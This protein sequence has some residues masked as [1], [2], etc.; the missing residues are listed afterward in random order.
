MRKKRTTSGLILAGTSLASIAG[1]A[2]TNVSAEGNIFGSIKNFFTGSKAEKSLKSQKEKIIKSERDGKLLKNASIFMGYDDFY[3]NKRDQAKLG[4]A[5]AV[6][7]IA[8]GLIAGALLRVVALPVFMLLFGGI[9]ALVVAGCVCYKNYVFKHNSFLKD[10][11]KARA[12]LNGRIKEDM[13]NKQYTL[14]EFEDIVK[15]NE[16]CS[17]FI[18]QLL[19]L[20]RAPDDAKEEDYK[21]LDN[22]ELE[23][24]KGTLKKLFLE[25]DSVDTINSLKKLSQQDKEKLLKVI[26]PLLTWACGKMPALFGEEDCFCYQK[27]DEFVSKICL[28]RNALDDAKSATREELGADEFIDIICN[29]KEYEKAPYKKGFVK[30]S[31][32]YTIKRYL[33]ET[34][35]D[36]KSIDD[37]L[38]LNSVRSLFKN[39]K[40]FDLLIFDDNNKDVRELAAA[41]F[42]SN[43]KEKELRDAVFKAIERFLKE[44][45]TGYDIVKYDN[46]DGK[47]ESLK[48][49]L[50]FVQ[51]H[52]RFYY[53]N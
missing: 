48:D 2:A 45:N 3:V 36:V 44:G 29:D 18:R 9:C 34:G 1:Q 20:E 40:Y 37:N 14:K 23:D 42:N 8:G 43:F 50:D 27:D 30:Y 24:A 22:G 19:V 26:D 35:L 33:K 38:L 41:E 7:S 52:L 5:G 47:K 51:Q 16:E 4:F 25:I 17:E 11:E 15:D 32:L 6:G 28:L 13:L 10:A 31:F 53:D 39:L 12:N 46:K 49:R 21:P